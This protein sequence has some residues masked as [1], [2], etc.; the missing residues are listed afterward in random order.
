MSKDMERHT[1]TVG[2]KEAHKIGVGKSH[3]SSILD[4]SDSTLR[5]HDIE[6]SCIESTLAPF[7]EHVC[8][9]QNDLFI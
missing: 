5:D 1:P 8:S 6:D 7:K 2:W 9:M 4:S 3:F